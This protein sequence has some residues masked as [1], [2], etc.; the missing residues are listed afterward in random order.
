VDPP[1][2]LRVKKA[3][4]AW[5]PRS[6]DIGELIP[7]GPVAPVGEPILIEPFEEVQFLRRTNVSGETMALVC[8]RDALYLVREDDL[9]T[10]TM[11]VI[12]SN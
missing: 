3:L 1:S 2:I 11:R 8:W 4:R 12:R 5:T 6:S 7:V 10:R 9:E